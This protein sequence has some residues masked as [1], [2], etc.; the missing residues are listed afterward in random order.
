MK[1]NFSKDNK[2]TISQTKKINEI[3]PLVREEYENYIG[4]LAEENSLEGIDWL[5][6]VTCRNTFSSNLH[7]R[8]CHLALIEEIISCGESIEEIVVDDFSMEKCL[9][10]YNNLF[11][12]LAIENFLAIER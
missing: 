12:L 9:Y 1:I 2:L 10:V 8:M 6:D 7:K 4:L 5:L 3:E 11:Y